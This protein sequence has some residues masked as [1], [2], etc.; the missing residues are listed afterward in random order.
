MRA[1]GKPRWSFTLGSRSTVLVAL[2]QVLADHLDAAQ[3]S[4]KRL[5]RISCLNVGA[6]R[7][8]LAEDAEQELGRCW[9]R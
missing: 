8:V 3:R 6:E 5:A 4:R 1:T 7:L 9:P 2:R